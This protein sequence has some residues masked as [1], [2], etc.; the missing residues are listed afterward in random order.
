MNFEREE[1]RIFIKTECVR[2]QGWR[3]IRRKSIFDDCVWAT[4]TM[5]IFYFHCDIL[6]WT[7]LTRS[8]YLNVISWN[9]QSARVFFASPFV[10]SGIRCSFQILAFGIISISCR[11]IVGEKMKQNRWFIHFTVHEWVWIW[12]LKCIYSK[13]DSVNCSVVKNALDSVVR[14]KFLFYFVSLCKWIF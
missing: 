3:E 2:K 11:D 14:W 13:C 5:H 1:V 12:I 9:S 4:P 6:G 7:I 8:K 10:L